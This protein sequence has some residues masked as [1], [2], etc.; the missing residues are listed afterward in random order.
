[1]T[2][3]QAEEGDPNSPL[4]NVRGYWCTCDYEPEARCEG[5]VAAYGEQGEVVS[6]TDACSG[7]PVVSAIENYP[8]PPEPNYPN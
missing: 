7:T 6:R 3:S 4:G 2:A 5:W 8:C 1:M